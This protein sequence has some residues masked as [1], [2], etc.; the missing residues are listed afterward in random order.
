MSRRRRL[1]PDGFPANSPPTANRSMN[2]IACRRAAGRIPRSCFCMVRRRA[3]NV[4]NA[5]F[6]EMCG[7]LADLGYYT[8][9]IEYFSQT[10]AVGA[11][12]PGSDQARLPD[13]ARGDQFG[14]RRTRQES[15]GR[16]SSSRPDGILARTR[17]CRSQPARSIRA[18]STA[19]VEYYGGLPPEPARGRQDDAADV[20]PARRQ[21]RAGA[22]GARR[23]RLDEL[24]TK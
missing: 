17:S 14:P 9:F 20:D 5:D 1:T 13:L 3:R 11:G 18:K 6:E 2:T 23:T 4:G 15:S 24:L 19:I 16:S 7:K 22:G 12:Q 10:D 8:E 21:G